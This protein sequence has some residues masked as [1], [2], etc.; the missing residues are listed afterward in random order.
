MTA[1]RCTIC[2]DTGVAGG[3]GI[4]YACTHCGVAEIRTRLDKIAPALGRSAV[5]VGYQAAQQDTCAA[6]ALIRTEIDQLSDAHSLYVEGMRAAL[7]LMEDK[8]AAP[9][10]HPDVERLQTALEQAQSRIGALITE[11]AQAEAR[12]A[13]LADLHVV[14]ATAAASAAPVVTVDTPEFE[15][16]LRHY[17]NTA[18]SF[19]GSQPA[20]N[21][22]AAVITHIDAHTDAA[23]ARTVEVERTA[24]QHAIQQAQQNALEARTQRGTVLDIL[25]HFGCP[26]EDWH[27][28]T[29][30]K[31][32][33]APYISL[34]DIAALTVYNFAYVGQYRTEEFFSA[35]AI[36]KL[37]ESQA[38]APVAAMPEGWRLVEKKTHYQLNDG[39][40]V[41]AS[42]AGPD[43]EANAAIIDRAL[44]APQQHA[45][46]ALSDNPQGCIFA[47]PDSQKLQPLVAA[48]FRDRFSDNGESWRAIAQY[49]LTLSRAQ[50]KITW[51]TA[52]AILATRQPT[53]VSPPEFCREDDGDLCL[54][55][56]VGDKSISVSFSPSGMVSW[57]ADGAS[58]SEQV[59]MAAPVAAAVAQG[60]PAAG[61]NYLWHAGSVC[62]K[63]GKVH[64]SPAD[65]AP[66]DANRADPGKVHAKT[67]LFHFA[68]GD[69]R[70]QII[71]QHGTQ[72][73]RVHG[74]A[75]RFVVEAIATA[76]RAASAFEK[77]A[78]AMQS[79]ATMA[80]QQ[81]EQRPPDNPSA[82]ADS[83][84]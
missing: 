80:A 29:L 30:I 14:Q 69:V 83:Q 47:H 35:T 22:R 1:P 16:V 6:L 10:V 40:T 77:A 72:E 12:A 52:R 34:D 56:R 51:D 27:A 37:F 64:Q 36:R 2:R 44:A 33:Q 41:V 17:Y 13:Q 74:D 19:M 73:V 81:I 54:D 71:D 7:E 24:K 55:W 18:S 67:E 62:N 65:A 15:E 4:G 43:A 23:V 53:P 9:A 8:V 76:N 79:D 11:K 49:V 38:P 28:L 21:A 50:Q 57:T 26:E 63:C 25:R 59:S 61:C 20:A 84:H 46:A 42:L 75:G 48:W 82:Y 70:L 58:G 39:N 78:R 66:V 45:Q 32:A 68:G 31:A 5:W 3:F 60:V